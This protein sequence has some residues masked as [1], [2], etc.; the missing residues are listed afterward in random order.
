MEQKI[1]NRREISRV[2]I[3]KHKF[4]GHLRD[5]AVK[6]LPDEVSRDKEFEIHWYIAHEI[7]HDCIM[8]IYKKTPYSANSEISYGIMLEL[9][10]PSMEMQMSTDEP[11]PRPGC[12][13]I[14]VHILR[15]MEA[16]SK[17]HKLGFH[18]DI[19]PANVLFKRSGNGFV[20]IDYE[21]FVRIGSEVLGDGCF[22]EYAP[23]PSPNRKSD[24]KSD[25]WSLACSLLE[26]LI[27]WRPGSNGGKPAVDLFRAEKK[28]EIEQATFLEEFPRNTTEFFYVLESNGAK[29]NPAVEQLLRDLNACPRTESVA[30]VLRKMLDVDPETRLTADEAFEQLKECVHVLLGPIDSRTPICSM[31]STKPCCFRLSNS[32]SLGR[33]VAKPRI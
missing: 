25:V 6:H 28:I 31:F 21:H 2:F 27:W 26:L 14:M 3:E 7:S 32:R 16:V 15:L 5:F 4:E 8:K 18:Q 17:L 20:L 9:E 29:L 33:E 12:I 22:S 11:V 19:K 30:P 23:P 1:D 13:C 10:G 24:G